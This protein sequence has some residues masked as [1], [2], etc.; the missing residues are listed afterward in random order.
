MHDFRIDD[1][2]HDGDLYDRINTFDHDLGFYR[3]QAAAV[4]GP[5]LELC[6]GTGRLTIPLLEAGIDVVGLDASPRM[7]AAAR[8]KAEARGLRATFLDG[9]MR[10][11]DLDRRFGL[12][13][14]SFNSLQCLYSVVDVLDTLEGVRRHLLPGGRVAFDVFNP[15]LRLILERSTGW[16]ETHRF[17]LDDGT[18]CVLSERCAYD[19]ASQ[20]NRITWR[21]GIGGEERF[22]RLDMRCFFPLEMDLYLERSGFVVLE[23]A[24]DFAG[25]PF[26]SGAPRMVYV[27]AAAGADV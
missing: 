21:Y 16:T 20:V 7:L 19:A 8:R 13:F 4:D 25:T 1:A 27:C 17:A 18:P 22:A 11:L 24:G 15:D 2:I 14:I 10:S 3:K 26:T 23:K 12:I 6:A 5:V 9:D